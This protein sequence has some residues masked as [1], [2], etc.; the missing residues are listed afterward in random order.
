MFLEFLAASPLFGLAGRKALADD[1]VRI[2]S[3]LPD[4]ISWGLLSADT[5]IK[6][7][8]EALSVFDF[9]LVARQNVPLAHFAKV[10]TGSGDEITMRAN[11]ADFAKVRLVPRR[12]RYVSKP[13]S[14][15]T[16]FGAKWDSPFFICPTGSV[17]AMHPD[18]NIAVSRAAEA[19]K[20]LQILAG[21]ESIAIE[22]CME[23]RGGTPIWFQLYPHFYNFEVARDII[24]RAESRGS[25]VLVLTIDEPVHPSFETLERLRRQDQRNCMDCHLTPAGGGLTRVRGGATNFDVITPEQWQQV[26]QW[27]ASHPSWG[28][29][30]WGPLN[31]DV[32]RRLRDSTKM[33]VVLKGV[34]AAEDASL[35]V[36][37]GF[38][39]IIVSNHGG[40][41]GDFGTTSISVL[42]GIAAAVQR[43]IP[44]LVDSGF[45]RGMDAVKALALG[46]TAVGIGRPYLWGL[47]AFGQAGVERVLEILRTE[48]M[49][50][51]AEV[52]ASTIED[53]R[54]L[55][56]SREWR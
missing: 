14:S 1:A 9:E 39:G 46:A 55:T 53:L 52:G 49:V 34:L 43:K 4:P 22:D 41:A 37:Y 16:L 20:H 51:M 56:V 17:K 31:W 7:P 29:M 23:A 24:A 3:P 10:A 5:L 27:R 42:P 44:I 15:I 50:S 21:A 40:R 18:G 30:S 8:Q 33:K 6:S 54:A 48:T 26:Q 25:P 32:V 12:L 2:P 35:C 19:G 47:G 45:R 11:R 38:D 13:D 28:K 36:K